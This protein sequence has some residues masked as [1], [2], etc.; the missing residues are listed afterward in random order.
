MSSSRTEEVMRSYLTQ[1]LGER[2]FELIDG[3]VAEDM[4]DHTQSITGPAA[5][6]AHARGFCENIPDVEIEILQIIATDDVAVGVWRWQ[7]TPKQSMGVSA[8]GSDIYP[9][10]VASIF[11]FRD[12]MLADYRAFV[13][14][15]EV[16]T[17][18]TS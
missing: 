4:V 16:R 6:H 5:L 7:G 17:Q 11:Q 12:G 1:V 9:H 2:R 18:I 8:A 3:F 13:D 10:L 15:T 14:A